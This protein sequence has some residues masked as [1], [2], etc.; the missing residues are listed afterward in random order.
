MPPGID[1]MPSPEAFQ[2]V[3]D[4]FGIVMEDPAQLGAMFQNDLGADGK[5][6]KRHWIWIG[7]TRMDTGRCGR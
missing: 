1:T 6:K 5:P 4:R 7:I 2:S 3:F